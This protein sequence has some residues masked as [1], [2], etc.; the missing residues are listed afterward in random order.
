MTPNTELYQKGTRCTIDH[1]A[2]HHLVALPCG[3]KLNI[4]CSVLSNYILLLSKQANLI[5]RLIVVSFSFKLVF[6]ALRFFATF[7]QLLQLVQ[8]LS[9]ENHL[10]DR[11]LADAIFD[12]LGQESIGRQVSL[13]YS[14]DQMSVGQMFFDQ[15]AWH[16]SNCLC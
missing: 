15:M 8:R 14:I 6:L 16:R 11:H 13:L 5:R 2:Q 1:L 12:Q 7:T 3:N 4:N 10:P 9:S